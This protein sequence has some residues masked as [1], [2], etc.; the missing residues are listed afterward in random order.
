MRMAAVEYA[1]LARQPIYD[2]QLDVCGY[3]LL[4]RAAPRDESAKGTGETDDAMLSAAT[5][6]AAL[7]DIGLDEIV[8]DR[9]AWV[10]VGSDVLLGHL[11][12]VL[13]PDRVVVEILDS[14][15][16]T[17][18][19][20]EAMAALKRTGYRFALDDVSLRP[21][22]GPV[23]A[24]ADV[25]KIDVLAH[26][27]DL[28]RQTEILGRGGADLLALKVEDHDMLDRC[29]TLGFTLFQGN[30][31]SRPRVV[32]SAKASLDASTRLQLAARL[33]DPEAGFDE[34]A[35]LIATD[36]ALS[37]RLLR[38]INS[39]H[40]GLRAPVGSIREALVV[41]GL[42][43][44]RS[45]ATLLLL[46]DAGGGRKELVATALL[47]ARMCEALSGEVSTDRDEAFLA[48]LLSVADA[49]VDRPLAE[50]LEALPISD[51]LR[52]ALLEHEGRLGELLERTL[53]YERGDFAAA[54]TYPF[55]VLGVARAY[56]E[57]I[58]WVTQLVESA[59]EAAAA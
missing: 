35:G 21:G 29:R 32:A 18:A 52:A 53:A 37:Y 47:R 5:L 34:L 49:L 46:A 20:V 55:S 33:G 57:G 14:L 54:T 8:G 26:A 30:V 23:L 16:A 12:E 39:A 40:V 56:I 17:P 2:A 36:P 41:L 7:T 10:N 11:S 50:A 19:I 1:C 58:R 25:V 24:L 27:D 42:R 28:E 9:P 13:P 6:T 51:G 45:W 15:A 44:V 43:R 22:I 59:S 48:G 31:F 3:E 38:Y 4:Y